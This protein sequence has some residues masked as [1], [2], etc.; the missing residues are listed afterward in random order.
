MKAPI[1]LRDGSIVRNRKNQ[2]LYHRYRKTIPADGCQFCDFALGSEPI[3]RTFQH[4]WVVQNLFPYH[5]WDSSQ[6]AEHLL[7]VPKR[8]VD[9]LAH[10]THDERVEYMAILAE[11][12]SNGFNIY[13]RSPGSGQKSVAHQHTH[14]IKSGKPISSQ[15]FINKPH[16]MFYR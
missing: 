12:E 5:I 16:I 14:F 11:Y 8:H 4:F 7:L 13:S 15:L 1:T 10:F 6:T 3:E 9:T 2:K